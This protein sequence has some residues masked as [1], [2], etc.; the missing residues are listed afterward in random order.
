MAIGMKNA[1]E[2]IPD[3]GHLFDF[4]INESCEHWNECHYYES[5]LK[6]R[7]AVFGVEYARKYVAMH[8]PSLG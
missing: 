4:A 1:L 5:F 8:R 2:L 6:Q 3:V 7:K